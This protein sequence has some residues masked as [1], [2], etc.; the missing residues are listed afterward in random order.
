MQQVLN[1]RARKALVFESPV[2]RRRST[3]F[4]PRP[5]QRNRADRYQTA[6]EFSDAFKEAIDASLGL[7]QRRATDTIPNA[8]KL[9]DA[10]TVIE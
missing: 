8:G 5:W 9:M 2:F 7:V 3:W 4:W 1:V 10:D 6:S